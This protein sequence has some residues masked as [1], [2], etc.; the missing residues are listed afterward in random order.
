MATSTVDATM[1]AAGRAGHAEAAELVQRE[2]RLA[3]G[4]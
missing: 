1:P 3:D 4:A 2:S